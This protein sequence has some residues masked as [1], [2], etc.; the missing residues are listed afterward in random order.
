MY[1]GD[2]IMVVLPSDHVTT[3]EEVFLGAIQA[4]IVQA[5]IFTVS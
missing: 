2:T 5:K 1:D 4:A 3:M